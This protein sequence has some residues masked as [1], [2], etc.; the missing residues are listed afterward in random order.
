MA[1]DFAG[2]ADALVA[3]PQFPFS[4]RGDAFPRT[5]R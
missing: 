2:Q 3:L 5:A 4:A 1:S